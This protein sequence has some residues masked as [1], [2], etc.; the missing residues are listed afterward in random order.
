MAEGETKAARIRAEAQAGAIEA[1]VVSMGKP[2]GQEA[3][4]LALSK[5][6]V[7]MYGEMGLKSNTM[8]F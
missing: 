8:F 5:E 7:K 4:A 3:A 6:Y 1:I 2:G